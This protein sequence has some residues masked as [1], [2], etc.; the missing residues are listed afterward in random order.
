MDIRLRAATWQYACMQRQA[1]G[2]E[3]AWL[4]VLR[5]ELCLLSALLQVFDGGYSSFCSGYGG[6]ADPFLKCYLFKSF[7]LSLYGCSLW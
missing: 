1:G 7:C 3:E 4:G 5:R 6:N 2:S